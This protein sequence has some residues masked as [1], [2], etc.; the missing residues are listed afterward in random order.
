MAGIN[1]LTRA[2]TMVAAL[3]GADTVLRSEEPQ[4]VEIATDAFVE[5]PRIGDLLAQAP[6]ARPVIGSTARQAAQGGSPA[7]PVLGSLA[8]IPVPAPL[9]GSS[10]SGPHISGGQPVNP[11]ASPEGATDPSTQQVKQDQVIVSALFSNNSKYKDNPLSK[12]LSKYASE[13][14]STI[15]QGPPN[16]AFIRGLTLILTRHDTNIDPIHSKHL[17]TL[18]DDGQVSATD[19]LIYAQSAA[20]LK[21]TIDEASEGMSPKVSQEAVKQYRD[22]YLR[23]NHNGIFVPGFTEPLALARELDRVHGLIENATTG[24]PLTTLIP[25]QK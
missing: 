25:K 9:P 5:G 1:S 13:H 3:T 12:A 24:S 10:P 11:G 23:S 7:R 18:V 6:A 14:Q 4:S 20:K 15:R 19:L 22:L 2:L 16:P 17:D 21:A 8:P